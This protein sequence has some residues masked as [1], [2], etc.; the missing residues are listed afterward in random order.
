MHA[1]WRC[2]RSLDNLLWQPV[3]HLRLGLCVAQRYTRLCVCICSFLLL[4]TTKHTHC[5]H[6]PSLHSTHTRHTHSLLATTGW[7]WRPSQATTHPYW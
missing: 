7:T 2:Q 4:P 1:C 5:S 6:S 3:S